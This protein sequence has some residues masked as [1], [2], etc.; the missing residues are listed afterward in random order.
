M[1]AKR[2]NKPMAIP[3]T[4]ARYYPR[5]STGPGDGEVAIKRNWWNQ[6]FNATLSG[7]WDH[8]KM[9][10]WFEEAKEEGGASV[11]YAVTYNP[12]V[13]R[14]LLLDLPYETLQWADNIT[15]SCDGQIVEVENKTDAIGPSTWVDP[16]PQFD[17]P[18]D[19]WWP[20]WEARPT[21]ATPIIKSTTTTSTTTTATPTS[22]PL[23]GL[24]ATAL[25]PVT[26]TTSLTIVSETPTTGSCETR[27]CPELRPSNGHKSTGA[28][29]GA[30]FA[31]FAVFVT[32]IALV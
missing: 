22:V 10:C 21:P 2:Y 29:F 20:R 12:L 4:G 15:Y 26:A 3:E 5:A 7:D 16:Q 19:V 28:L 27:N 25:E 1:F 30:A 8:L 18:E 6:V 14:A 13:R 17:I 23:M 32:F 9:V 24:T 11:D 31:G